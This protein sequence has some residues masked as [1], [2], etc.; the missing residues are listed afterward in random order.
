MPLKT[1]TLRIESLAMGGKG[2]ARRPDGKVVFVPQV[3]PGEVVLVSCAAEHASYCEAQLEEIV[4]A[5]PSRTAPGCALFETCGG[6]D[7]QHIAYPAQL[8][9][10][11]ELLCQALGKCLPDIASVLIPPEPAPMTL[12]YRCHS[13]LHYRRFPQAMLGFY[14]KRTHRV[15]ACAQCPVLN[16]PSQRAL[17][18]LNDAIRQIPL[19]GITAVEIYAPLDEVLVLA[20]TQNP[21]P[22]REMQALK[23][24][25]DRIEVS[26]C[27]L[28]HDQTRRLQRLMGHDLFTYRIETPVKNFRLSGRL[29][30]FIQANQEMN[31]RVVRHVMDL[32]HDAERV[33]D[34]YGGCGNFGLPLSHAARS[35][36]VVERDPRLADLGQ[37]NAEA[38]RIANIRFI[39]GDVGDALQNRARDRFDTVVLDPPREGAKDILS[40]LSGLRPSKIIYVSCNPMTLARDAGLLH[41]S[42]YRINSLKLFDMFPQTCH[43]E[44]VALMEP[45]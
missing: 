35:V 16:P 12:A 38:N 13:R 29:G 9:F 25:M 20:H 34:L 5:A 32:A 10:K 1:Y 28:V 43:I 19:P 23:K 27:H 3:I 37:R 33:L 4:Q 31:A 17:R 26:G 30:G 22:P 14:Q 40:T 39:A 42:G 18:Q 24:L 11:H 41:K 21:R 36:T 7:W 44:S 8:A 6:C 45:V 2:V 15:A